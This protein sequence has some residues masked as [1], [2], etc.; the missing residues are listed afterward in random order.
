MSVERPYVL[1]IAGFDPSSGAGLSA[2]IKT[3]ERHRT[4]GLAVNT[5]NTV[6]NDSDFSEVFWLEIDQIKAQIDQLFNKWN[7]NFVKIGLVQNWGVLEEIIEHLFIKNSSIKIILDPIFK[8][9]SSFEFDRS[10]EEILQKIL[11]K[12]YLITPNY[13]EFEQLFKNLAFDDKIAA[14]TEKT[15]LLLKGG[16]RKDIKGKDE[17]FCQRSDRDQ[18]QFVFAPKAKNISDKHG[19]GCILSASIV[20]NLANGQTLMKSCF[21]A[22]QYTEKAMQSNK[23]L[24][25]YHF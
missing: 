10:N 21:R 9:S 6:Q 22:K 24:L 12:V 11:E 25:A 14:I 17:L 7:I 18:K 2:D 3:F 1:T 19:T 5:A 4:Y 15:N 8:S 23:S 13:D 20:A 16:H